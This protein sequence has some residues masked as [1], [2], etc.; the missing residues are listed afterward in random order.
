MLVVVIMHFCFAAGEVVSVKGTSLKIPNIINADV[1]L[2]ISFESSTSSDKVVVLAHLS[3]DPKTLLAYLLSTTNCI[4]APDPGNYII[5]VF[6]RNAGS[7]MKAPVT[8][9]N[10]SVLTSEYY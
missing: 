5:G 9:P 7:A 1:N 4:P 6:T 10:I 3:D 8:P 2:C